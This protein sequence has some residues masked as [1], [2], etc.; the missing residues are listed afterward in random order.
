MK[1]KNIFV[2]AL[3]MAISVATAGC[4]GQSQPATGGST[5]AGTETGLEVGKL[6]PTFTVKDIDGKDVTLTELRDKPAMF[7]FTATWCPRCKNTAKALKPYYDS[8][9]EAFRVLVVGIDPT[10]GPEKL[11]QWKIQNGHPDWTYIQ[12]PELG[13][14]YNTYAI[15]WSYVVDTTGTI[16]YVGGAPSADEKIRELI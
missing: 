13:V 10:E 12:S 4:V 9:G 14:M 3:L 7:F 11:R 15:D 8:T 6:A 2:L 1:A 5:A 16:R